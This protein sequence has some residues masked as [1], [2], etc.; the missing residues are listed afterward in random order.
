MGTTFKIK[1]GKEL[2]LNLNRIDGNRYSLDDSRGRSF[3]FF[4]FDEDNTISFSDTGELA[5]SSE[6][7]KTKLEGILRREVEQKFTGIEDDEEMSVDEDENDPFDPEEVSIDTKPIT[8]ETLLR[9]LEQ[10]SIK[11]NPDFQRN[12]VWSD[13]RKSQLIESLLLKIPIPM[14]YVSSD[15]KSNWTVV[16]GL[17]R[18]STFRDFVLG[19]KF[20]SDPQKNR[21]ERGNG[22]R[23]SRLE[24]WRKLE[25]LRMN[26]LPPH[27]Y[28]RVI[29][30]VFTFTIINP[31]THEEVKRNIFKRL[32]TGGMPLSSQEIRN[33]LYTGTSTILLN[34]LANMKE[35]K[36]ATCDSIN[37]QRLEDRE[38]ILRFLSFLVRKPKTYRRTLNIDTWLSDTM[39]IINALPNLDSREIKKCIKQKTIN[40]D[41][42]EHISINGIKDTFSLAMKRAHKLFGKHAFRKSTDNMRRRPINKSLFEAW[43]VLL[44]GMTEIQFNLLCTNKKSFMV[45]YRRLLDDEAFSIAISRDSMKHLSVKLR[46]EKLTEIINKYSR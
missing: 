9:R 35:F 25:G 12:E 21:A 5:E 45:E 19:K 17:Q 43:G 24:F 39:I 36:T 11:L 31:G 22:M 37:A 4:F 18:I 44:S 7:I 40:L 20:L 15:E 38:L 30:T 14:F 29:E 41:D 1:N 26:D 6:D 33:A 42:I 8:M 32:N 10:G 16:D 23:L 3:F 34:E 13:D 2:L 46:F 28:N 27:L